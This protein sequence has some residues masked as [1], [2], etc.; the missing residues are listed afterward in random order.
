ME[1]FTQKASWQDDWLYE[2]FEIVSKV[3]EVFLIKASLTSAVMIAIYIQSKSFQL[4][5]LEVMFE[6]VAI[7]Y[8]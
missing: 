5:R 1:N 7:N 4:I 8:T 3:V 6:D 2:N